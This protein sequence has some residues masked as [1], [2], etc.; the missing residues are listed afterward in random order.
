[1][2]LDSFISFLKNFN[3]LKNVKILSLYD[4]WMTTGNL[5]IESFSSI[6]FTKGL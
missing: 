4:Y 2:T 3:L 6:L 5:Q 1:M